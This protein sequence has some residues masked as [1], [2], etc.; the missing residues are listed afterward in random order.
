MVTFDGSCTAWDEAA[1][2]QAAASDLRLSL[3]QLQVLDHV[4]GSIIVSFFLFVDSSSQLGTAMDQFGRWNATPGLFAPLGFGNITWT[5]LVHPSAPR[6]SADT[7][8]VTFAADSSNCSLWDAAR[9]TQAAAARLGMALDQLVVQDDECTNGNGA[10]IA[11]AMRTTSAAELAVASSRFL[12]WNAQPG[13]FVPLGVGQI[14]SAVIRYASPPPSRPRS[15]PPM[16]PAPPLVQGAPSP[17]Q[18][19][20][21]V[22]PEPHKDNKDDG[23]WRPGVIGGVVAAAVVILFCCCCMVG[24]GSKA[25]P[26]LNPFDNPMYEEQV[27]IAP[28]ARS[29]ENRPSPREMARVKSERTKRALEVDTEEVV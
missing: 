18:A 15:P 14:S 9:F 19:P 2:R 1:F 21:S 28:G 8:L 5:G 27:D 20:G 11:F 7:F 10:S 12:A 3:P 13:L 26:S 22:P 17:P 16:T 25:P 23:F 6:V 4:C 29:Y 24:K